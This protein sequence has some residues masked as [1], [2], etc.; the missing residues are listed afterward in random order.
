M[1]PSTGVFDETDPRPPVPLGGTRVVVRPI[2]SAIQ[3]IRK[4]N[5]LDWG[6]VR[7]PEMSA[8]VR[9]TRVVLL[10]DHATFA[11]A[12]TISLNLTADLNC[13]AATTDPSSVEELARV[14]GAQ[15]VISDQ[16]L[17]DGATGMDLLTDLRGRHP[18]LLLVLLTA[19]PT[20]GV[21]AE[22][23]G[24]GVFVLSKSTSIKD[25]VISLRQIVQG[26][27]PLAGLKP[28]GD[29]VLSPNEQ[30]VLELLG[31]GIRVAEIADVQSISVHTAR[32]HVKAILRKLDVSSQLEA[33][34][35]AQRRGLIAPPS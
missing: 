31:Q 23:A 21:L 29:A 14:T 20:P 25:I 18:R 7:L 30:R 5:P 17:S 6:P 12:L 1:S 34:I 16:H 19:F 9:Q 35:V 8:D 32:D 4:Q 10:D 24:L 26:F 11:D 13:I 22:A 33:V 27:T 2:F 28:S 3:G 15:M